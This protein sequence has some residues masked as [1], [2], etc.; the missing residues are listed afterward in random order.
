MELNVLFLGSKGAQIPLGPLPCS[1]EIENLFSG[2]PCSPV[3][4]KVWSLLPYSPEIND[5][6]PLFPKTH[7]RASEMI[8]FSTFVT[9]KFCIPINDFFVSVKVAPHEY[10]IRTGQP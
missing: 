1:P 9:F 6:F 3:P 10:V 4:I 7:V 2:V 8:I 5:M